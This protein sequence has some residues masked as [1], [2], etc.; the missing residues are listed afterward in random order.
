M[1]YVKGFERSVRFEEKAF[2]D[3]RFVR[4]WN[5]AAHTANMVDYD[6]AQSDGDDCV[7]YA[8]GFDEESNQENQEQDEDNQAVESNDRIVSYGDGGG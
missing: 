2:T 1:S 5:G 6:D 8:R 7:D 4:L 3:G